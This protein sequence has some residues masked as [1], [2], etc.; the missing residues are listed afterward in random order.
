LSQHKLKS[1]DLT[2]LNN[3]FDDMPQWHRFTNFGNSA[4]DEVWV[5]LLF[6]SGVMNT[7]NSSI[8]S[9]PFRLRMRAAG[10]SDAW[11]NFPEFHFASATAKPMKR[12]IR[13]KFSAAPF[14]GVGTLDGTKRNWWYAHFQPPQ[15]SSTPSSSTTGTDWVSDGYFGTG[16]G[17]NAYAFAG[18]EGSTKL[19]NMTMSQDG[20]TFWLSSSGGY[21]AGKW[22]FEL[23]RGWAYLLTSF[24]QTTYAYG[25]NTRDF[26]GGL[27]STLIVAQDQTGFASVCLLIRCISIYNG[28]VVPTAA[29]T[30]FALLAIKATNRQINRLSVIAW[31]QLETWNGS[32]WVWD[33]AGSLN[34]AEQYR[35]VLLGEQ[36]H[37]P[38]DP[39]MF[40]EQTILD[41]RQHCIDFGW[42]VDAII[43]D[44]RTQD[45]LT[46]IASCG[47]AKP[48]QSDLYSVVVDKDVSGDAPI[49]V[50][51]RVNTSNMKYEKAFARVPSGLVITYHNVNTDFENDQVVVDQSDP[52]VGITGLY[53]NISYDGLISPAEVTA[54]GQFDLD[55]INLRSTFYSFETDIESLVCR[56]GSLVAIQHD[57]LTSRAG[58]AR[59]K[60]YTASA[61]I[62]T[63]LV[64]DSKIHVEVSDTGIAIRHTDG[65]ISTHTV[66]SSIPT[67]DWD[68]IVINSGPSDNGTVQGFNQTN[69]EYGSLVVSGKLSTVYQRMLVFSITPSKD[70]RAS[71]VLV[72]EAQDL[73]RLNGG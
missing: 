42:S 45:V 34:P 12:Q 55:Q 65:S 49:Q 61:G 1:D 54:R 41:W 18:V 27:N 5:H 22:E 47:Y 38:I 60:S 33:S 30:K 69:N 7:A 37:D 48:Y 10:S 44:M 68:T 59:I 71:V 39:T 24:N 28:D 35:D 32:S 16:P 6:P 51:S 43:D 3:S 8:I 40:D 26:F 36:N 66:S 4:P 19:N 62:I 72:D 70:L 58:D 15:Q 17:G 57:V 9:V 63:T 53:E 13:I 2:F 64:L 14:T 56:R 23:I 50:F 67:G 29:R 73:V 52:S 31:G 11:I 21:A 20:I 46:L 25:G